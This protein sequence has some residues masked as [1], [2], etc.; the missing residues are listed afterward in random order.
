MCKSEREGERESDEGK[1]RER[2]NIKCLCLIPKMQILFLNDKFCHNVIRVKFSATTVT[3][4][5]IHTYIHV[6]FMCS[7]NSSK[8]LLVRALASSLRGSGIG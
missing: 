4:I 1:G 7:T 3:R 2:N 6:Y 8:W 5:K